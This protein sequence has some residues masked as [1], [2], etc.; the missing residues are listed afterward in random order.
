MAKI[1]AVLQF[2]GEADSD[3]I[4]R[5]RLLDLETQLFDEQEEQ[6]LR[7]IKETTRYDITLS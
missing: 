5:D 3:A 6:K 7:K 2:L 1:S 4:E